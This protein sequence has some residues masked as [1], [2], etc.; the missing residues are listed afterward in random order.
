MKLKNLFKKVVGLPPPIPK[1]VSKPVIDWSV[2]KMRLTFLE[3][4][5][6]KKQHGNN[7]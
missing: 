1:P 3:Y 2:E 6:L 7:L 4:E 5:E